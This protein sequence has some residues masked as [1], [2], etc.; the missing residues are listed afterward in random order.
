MH[1]PH[2]NTE[3]KVKTEAV[4]TSSHFFAPVRAVQKKMSIGSSNDAYEVEA[5]NVANKAMLMAEPQHQNVS[6]SGSLVQRKCAACEKE[7]KL[8]MKPLSDSIT[9]LIQKSSAESGGVSHAPSNVEN[10]INSSRGGGSIMD[11]G[12]KSFME[13]RFS[14]DFSDVKIHTGSQAVQMSRELNA[15]AF[16][17]GNDI[18]FNEGKYSPNSDSGKHLLAHEL[19][20]TVQQGGG[21][22]R[23]VQK[24][25]IDANV[26]TNTPI[27]TALGLT[28]QE[29]ID[30]IRAAN[31]E[32]I[33]LSQSAIDSLSTE[34]ANGISGATVDANTE[35]I[36]N[37]ELGLSFLN[38]AQ[39]SLIRQQ[40]NRFTRVRTS[41]ESGYLRYL[42]LG[43]G[44]ISLVGCSA[45]TCANDFAFTCPGNRLLVLCQ[46]FW[47]T[48]NEM[49]ATIMHETFHI[50]FH[51]AQH[52]NSALRRADASCLESFAM[53][54]SGKP[55][56]A[57]CIAH[58]NG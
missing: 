8:Q 46:T 29:I 37:E 55:A 22:E 2:K 1:Q 18:Y 28:R 45:G 24:S 33:T 16:T 49:G 14:I 42:A 57:T 5:D 52:S 3:T 34:L 39:H 36:L 53:R 40:I 30:T 20:H 7:E 15:Q 25:V 43:I 44:N 19:T 31:T 38:R 23:K 50:W 9:P 32:A 21:I 58:T 26:V 10:Q 35:L 17:V 56:P 11:H 4:K 12:T 47:D 54:V 27:E 48:P 6:Q 13:S 41:L 51:M